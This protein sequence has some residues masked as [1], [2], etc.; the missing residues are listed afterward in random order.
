[1]KKRIKIDIVSDIMCPWCI[2]GF[3][4]LKKAMAKFEDKAE[5]EI[6]W[7]PFELAPRMADEGQLVYERLAEKYSMTPEQI[8]ATHNEI[9]SMAAEVG[10]QFNYSRESRMYN[11]FNA[12]QIIHW[13][14]E[15]S[16]QQSAIKEAI[17]EAHFTKN[18]NVS[19][20]DVLVDV[21][22]SVGLDEKEARKILEEQTYA[23]ELRK[24]EREI[25]KAGIKSVPSYKFND[26]HKIESSGSVE[27]FSDMIEKIIAE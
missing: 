24:I 25:K 7:H 26:E 18:L 9:T 4:R 23:K 16:D 8:L 5:F 20:I 21:V 12:H 19:K 1:M 3:N 11:T 17:F 10:F 22:K 13:A 15:V 14:G 6:H 27:I 2:V